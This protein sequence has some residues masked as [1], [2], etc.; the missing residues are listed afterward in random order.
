MGSRLDTYQGFVLTFQSPWNLSGVTS[1]K[2]HQT[3][4]VSGTITHNDADAETAAVALAQPALSLATAQTSLIS[5]AYYPAG[6]LV[7][8]VNKTYPPTSHPGT[9]SAYSASPTQQQQLEVVP[10]PG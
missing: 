8:T 1:H 6:S 10:V 9:G 2:W 3:F 4:Y 7:S 5:F